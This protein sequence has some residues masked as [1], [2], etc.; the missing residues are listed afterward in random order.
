[1]MTLDEFNRTLAKHKLKAS[2]DAVVSIIREEDGEMLVEV[3]GKRVW[4]QKRITE[5]YTPVLTR[6][7]FHPV[8]LA[9]EFKLPATPFKLLM[10]IKSLPN[11]QFSGAHAGR[12]LGMSVKTVRAAI[13]VLQQESMI[14]VDMNE[15]VGYTV[16][17]IQ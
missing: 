1:M 16:E 8:V 10:W 3:E 7:D 14:H 17:V 13:K 4:A 11:K 6:S 12:T 9:P 15:G 5:P 2:P